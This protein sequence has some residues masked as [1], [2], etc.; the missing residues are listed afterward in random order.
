MR[1]TIGDN[2]SQEDPVLIRLIEKEEAVIVQACRFAGKWATILVFT[3]DGTVN[4]YRNKKGFGLIATE[5][6]KDY[7]DL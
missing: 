1:Y 7:I 2:I 6:V 5:E 3:P 4:M